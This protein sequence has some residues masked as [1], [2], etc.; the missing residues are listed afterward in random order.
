MI[1]LHE[2]SPAWGINPS[3]FCLK[4]ETYLRLAG[5]PF[6]PVS[7][8]P[9]RA[10]KRKLP[11]IVDQGRRIADSGHIIAYL[12][13]TYGDPL[14][15]GFSSEQQA[16]GHLMR[17]TC[18]ESLY[19][20]LLYARW[21][22]EPGWNVIRKALF[23]GL[24]PVARDLVPRLVR[25][26]VARSLNGQGYGRHSRDEIYALG[27]TD[28]DALAIHLAARPFAVAE[29]PTSFDACIYAFLVSLMRPPIELPLKSHALAK[30]AL[31]QY[32]ERMEA[33]L[34]EAAAQ[35]QP[36]PVQYRAE[37]GP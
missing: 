2:F 23:G 31:C 30:P 16:L 20:V 33:V 26:G 36:A 34:A 17:R 18:E 10:P 5:L 37:P 14:D 15:R 21:M 25:R 19:F 12:Q 6:R 8:V 9:F 32:V 29:R 1:E 3:P 22:D 4:V 35:Q 27:I 24:P 11:V 13:A 7:S 28:L